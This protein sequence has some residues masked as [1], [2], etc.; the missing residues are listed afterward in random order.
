[1]LVTGASGFVGANLCRYF[2]NKGFNVIALAGP[3]WAEMRSWRLSGLSESRRVRVLS[4]DLEKRSA[5]RELIAEL[6]P[7]VVVHCAAY[8]A[9][10]FQTDAE[11]IYG[12]NFHGLRNLLDALREDPARTK[13]K[14][15]LQMGTSS[16]YG[17]NCSGPSED[18]P[19]L[20]D[21]HYSV[22]KNS[23][24]ALIR[25]YARE[26]RVPACVLRLY[27]VYGPFEEISRLI[28]TLLLAAR[29]GRLP[30]LVDPD[31]SRDFVHVDDVGNAVSL[32]LADFLTGGKAA[33]E[34]FNI[35]SG[36]KT[37]IADLVRLS[38]ELFGVRESPCWNSMRNRSWDHPDWF[39]NPAKANATFGWQSQLS[40]KEGL[41]STMKWVRENP[42]LIRLA[43]EQSLMQVTK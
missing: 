11:R 6:R 22:S 29:E 18:A 4:L 41:T 42:E 36:R 16:E 37:T 33:G 2:A 14:A 15:F 39:C 17:R 7:A 32:L 31:I 8:G 1:M 40:L 5:V 30:P 34:V 43:Q 38:R 21:S 3:S 24:T 9:Y 35:G 19:T 10:S 27:S 26:L 25:Y 12:V 20:P 28:P 23:A 13:L